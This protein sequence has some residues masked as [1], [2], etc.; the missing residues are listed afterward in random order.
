MCFHTSQTQK[1]I[2]LEKHYKVSLTD[3]GSR[4]KYDKPR[5]H[6]NGFSHPDMLI[7]PQEEPSVITPG[8]WGIV[9][10]NKTASQITD[11]YKEAVRYGGGLNARSEKL[12]DHFI[13]KHSVVSKR[14][15]VP[16]TG[17][18]EPHEYKGKKYPFHIKRKD[19]EVLSLAGIYTI[20][21]NVFTFTIL[22]KSASPLL[23]KIHNKKNRQPV[24]LNQDIEQEW[25]K[26]NISEKDIMEL[27][28]SPYP[29]SKLS[30]YTISKEL[31]SPK[32][33][34]N[35]P[36]IIDEVKYEGLVI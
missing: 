8:L 34:S 1:V 2:K 10:N 36:S 26:D 4:E 20:I 29:E 3:E 12:F 6:L 11:Y 28:N 31:F 27:I 9:P 23:A 14:C 22:T 33:N 7:I 21:D 15:I 32:V 24:L 25:L 16:V 13:Y 5:Y 30:T 35:I 17:F 18:F 19:D